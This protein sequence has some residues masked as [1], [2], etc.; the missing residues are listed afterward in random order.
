MRYA[1]RDRSRSVDPGTGLM[2]L[3]PEEDEEDE[4][5]AENAEEN[6][7]IDEL[8]STTR[9]RKRALKI[10]QSANQLPE[11]GMWRSLAS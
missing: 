9:G 7:K 3:L 8:L 11:A 6:A 1:E 5:E 10:L 4:S 2:D